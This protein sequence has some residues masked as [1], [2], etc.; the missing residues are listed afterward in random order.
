MTHEYGQKERPKKIP[1]RNIRHRTRR[2]GE[3]TEAKKPRFKRQNL[4]KARTADKWRKPRGIDSK[5]RQGVKAKG[6][7]PRVGYGKPKKEI[8]TIIVKNLADMKKVP[9]NFKVIIAKTVGAKKKNLL[10][11]TA[12]K[13]KIKIING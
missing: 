10:K 11:E 2:N 3:M 12:D 8:K 13:K 5:Q 4:V 7:H 9:E 6:A 1:R